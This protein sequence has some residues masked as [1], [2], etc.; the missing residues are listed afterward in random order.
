MSSPVPVQPVGFFL[1]RVSAL[2]LV[3]QRTW[4]RPALS[5]GALGSP[6]V[7]LFL[8]VY[9]V[10]RLAHWPFCFPPHYLSYDSEGGFVSLFSLS[11][12]FQHIPVH[13]HRYF[14]RDTQRQDT[15]IF[16]INCDCCQNANVFYVGTTSR[17][18][19]WIQNKSMEPRP[20]ACLWIFKFFSLIDKVQT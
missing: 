16:H 9:T 13:W 17:F 20:W 15:F 12:F 8:A 19:S 4:E 5:L 7:R 11:I 3:P 2:S 10:N 14:S 18:H 6:R 1:P